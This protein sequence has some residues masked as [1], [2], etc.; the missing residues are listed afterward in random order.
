MAKEYKGRN[1]ADVHLT[2]G[3][4]EVLGN[5]GGKGITQIK[6]AVEEVQQK[7]LAFSNEVVDFWSQLIDDG[8]IT[9][10]E[11][12]QFKR[13]MQNVEQ[14]YNA[15][16]KQALD[17][18]LTGNEYWID[19]ERAHNDLVTYINS[20][21]HLFDDMQENTEIPDR[22]QFDQY[23]NQYYYSEKF[24]QIA[25]T[26]GI[27]GNLGFSVI[28][29]LETPG[30]E[31][32]V[33][34]YR[35]QLYQF[36]D[37]IWQAV[38]LEGYMGTTTEL[39][40]GSQNK[41]FMVE[42]DFDVVLPLWVNN[43]PLYV[44]DEKL[45]VTQTFVRG[46][47][48]VYQEGAWLKI[49][50][51]SNYRYVVALIDYINVTGELP[52]AFQDAIDDAEDR[53]MQTVGPLRDRMED[54]PVYMGMWTTD[55]VTTYEGD[56]YLYSGVTTST[57][58]NSYIYKRFRGGWL[59]CD[60]NNSE[61]SHLYM[62]AL[63]DILKI[64]NAASGY[65]ASIFCNSFFANQATLNS[66]SVRVIRLNA[67]GAIQSERTVFVSR[68]SG[69]RIDADGKAEFNNDVYI[70]GNTTIAGTTNI[71][72]NTTIGGNINITGSGTI[73]ENVNI[74]GTIT[75]GGVF[76][77][78]LEGATGTFSGDLAAA[79]GTFSGDLA[80]ASGTFKGSLEAA[81]GTFNGAINTNGLNLVTRAGGILIYD[82]TNMKDTF[83]KCYR[84][85]LTNLA[86]GVLRIRVEVY[87]VDEE[88]TISVAVGDNSF[89]TLGTTSERITYQKDIEVVPG[90]IAFFV[91]PAS[92]TIHFIISADYR[93]DLLKGMYRTTKQLTV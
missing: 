10:P 87:N 32:Q 89:I 80:A 8:I 48:Y 55:P 68:T 19:Y 45:V 72:G 9:P 70:G 73:G 57:R 30:T 16:K 62:Q 83:T 44:N 69:M 34:L 93:N 24:T 15:L 60:P 61:T 86:S 67:G 2:V 43:E 11:K 66:L 26:T 31:G 91:Q 35:G 52:G 79:G 41:Y 75:G 76:T 18:S 27:I 21:L 12:E 90:Y 92:A 49:E 28:P 65:F 14:S 33:G 4:L 22:E 42:D 88:V 58:K 63:E 74:K 40:A 23:F 36:T 50:D 46:F 17:Q 7:N 71:G 39:P 29:D 37:G 3:S 85:S 1:L 78:K 64:N 5:I 6:K 25:M 82:D 47:I 81:S 20:T 54:V 53:I 59:E 56:F 77:G 84:T 38:G 13:E 51:T